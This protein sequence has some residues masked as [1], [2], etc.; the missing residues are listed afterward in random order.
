[1][2]ERLAGLLDLTNVLVEPPAP[3]GPD[4]VGKARPLAGR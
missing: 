4:E 3:L 2:L 1:V